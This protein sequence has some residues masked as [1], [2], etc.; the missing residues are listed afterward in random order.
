MSM[1]K[2]DW[3]KNAKRNLKTEIV[4][5]GITYKMLAEGLS[6]DSDEVVTERAV[7]SKISRGSFS[8]AFY[9]QCMR[10]IEANDTKTEAEL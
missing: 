6:Q 3:A 8:H 7:A 4:K 9:L 2:T 10:V 1:Q 5:R